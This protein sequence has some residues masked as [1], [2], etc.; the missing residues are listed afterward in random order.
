M[1][2]AEATNRALAKV[3]EQA[4]T[5]YAAVDAARNRLTEELTRQGDPTGK[6]L[7]DVIAA[8]RLDPPPARPARKPGSQFENHLESWLSR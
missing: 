8:T 2:I 6:A 1:S 4:A 7:T 3:Q 5:R